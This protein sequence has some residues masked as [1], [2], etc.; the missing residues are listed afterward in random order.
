M[1]IS[2]IMS[3]SYD[4]DANKDNKKANNIS[5]CPMYTEYPKK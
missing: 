1:L 2:E 3:D 5:V 4:R